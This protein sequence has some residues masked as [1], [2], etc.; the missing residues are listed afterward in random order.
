MAS[1]KTEGIVRSSLRI[2]FV[3]VG[4]DEAATSEEHRGARSGRTRRAGVERVERMPQIARKIER[5][6]CS[7]PDHIEYLGKPIDR[8]SI[9]PEPRIETMLVDYV[10][11]ICSSIWLVLAILHLVD[12]LLKP[13]I[14]TI[15]NQLCVRLP[16]LFPSADC[17]LVHDS[18]KLQKLDF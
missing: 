18:L 3:F 15:Y 5:V 10:V 14:K 6:F 8:H 16:R 13:R 12:N 4:K 2:G 1:G 9:D 17:H 7:F 11:L